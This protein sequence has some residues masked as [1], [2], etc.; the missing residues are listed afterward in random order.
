MWTKYTVLEQSPPLEDGFEIYADSKSMV[1][2]WNKLLESWKSVS[3]K[4]LHFNYGRIRIK[5]I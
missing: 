3:L 4:L 1:Y 5:I 2:L